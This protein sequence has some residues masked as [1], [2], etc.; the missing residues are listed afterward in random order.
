[1]DSRTG[2]LITATQEE[3]GVYIW[4]VKN[5]LYFKISQ[6]HERPFLSN[7]D[8]I[9]IQVQFN[10][11]LRKALGIHQCFL[12]CRIWTR[13]RPQTW[14]FLRVF[15]YQC[16]K[17]LNSLGV[18]SINNVIRAMSHVL[19]NVLEGTIDAELSHI[20]KFNIY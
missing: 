9:T 13:L 3:S 2:E 8:I 1:M 11:N 5:P 17:Y 19:Y 4:T 6:H 12:I 7:N 14:R 20:I 16:M 18:I 10:Y 15:K